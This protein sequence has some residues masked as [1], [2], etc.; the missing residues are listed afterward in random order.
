VPGV[1]R[2]S[3]RGRTHPRRLLLTS[4]LYANGGPLVITIAVIAGFILALSAI[5]AAA[6]LVEP[7][8]QP[9]WSFFGIADEP[10]GGDEK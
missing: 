6:S 8:L 9:V 10:I 5:A 2:R 3:S 4:V 7:H 1:R